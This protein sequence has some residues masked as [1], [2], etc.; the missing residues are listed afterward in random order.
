MFFLL[1]SPMCE[2]GLGLNFVNIW[3]LFVDFDG[4]PFCKVDPFFIFYFFKF[5]V[6]VIIIIELSSEL[7]FEHL[8]F[9][10]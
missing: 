10:Q 2:F 8:W 5:W 4:V 6:F 1:V 7:N 3:F 9:V